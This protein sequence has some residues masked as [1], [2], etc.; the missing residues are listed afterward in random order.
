MREHHLH[1]TVLIGGA[2]GTVSE[3]MARADLL[4]TDAERANVIGCSRRKDLDAALIGM[5]PLD[6]S[7][8]LLNRLSRYGHHNTLVAVLPA[9]SLRCKHARPLPTAL[10]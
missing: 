10:E 5:I 3:S 8:P 7:F 4:R 2:R 9:S 6:T 1:G